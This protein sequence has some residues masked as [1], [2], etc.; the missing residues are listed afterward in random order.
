MGS[1]GMSRRDFL[2]IGGGAGVASN[3]IFVYKQAAWA[4]G[5]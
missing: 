4:L 2:R 1:S 3:Q 5:S